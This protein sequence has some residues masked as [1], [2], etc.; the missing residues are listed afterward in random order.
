MVFIL[1]CTLNVTETN[2]DAQRDHDVFAP[3]RDSS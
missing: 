1:L 2:S 3:E